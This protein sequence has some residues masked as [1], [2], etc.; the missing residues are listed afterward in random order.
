MM[1]KMMM[2]MFSFEHY[3]STADDGENDDE[4]DD[5]EDDVDVDVSLNSCCRRVRISGKNF[6]IAEVILFF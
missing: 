2:W 4:D 6:K 1:K 3:W 5:D